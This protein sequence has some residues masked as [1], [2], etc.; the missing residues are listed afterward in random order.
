MPQT[1][2]KATCHSNAQTEQQSLP[3]SSPA[4][5][6]VE[7]VPQTTKLPSSEKPIQVRMKAPR[8]NT[9]NQYDHDKNIYADWF[10]IA[11]GLNI[12][13]DVVY[14]TM[15]NHLCLQTKLLTSTF[16]VPERVLHHFVNFWTEEMSAKPHPLK[17]DR[18]PYRAPEN[19][20]GQFL[21]YKKFQ[22]RH[23]NCIESGC[24]F[25][26]KWGIPVH[27]TNT[28]NLYVKGQHGLKFQPVMD[29]CKVPH[30]IQKQ[31]LSDFEK[32]HK[33]LAIAHDLTKDLLHTNFANVIPTLKQ[34]RNAKYYQRC[35]KR[36]DHDQFVALKRNVLL[37]PDQFTMFTPK[38]DFEAA[39][40]NNFNFAYASNRLL[41]IG[42]EAACL[43]CGFDGV[44]KLAQDKYPVYVLTTV[45]N[46]L[47]CVPLAIFVMKTN[48]SENLCC[49]LT[50]FRELMKARFKMNW[51]PFVMID[52]G[53]AEHA[54]CKKADLIYILCWFHMKKTVT[55]RL[56]SYKLD[57]MVT[58][59]I[60][61][62]INMMAL[63]KSESTYHTVFNEFK[64][65]YKQT[66]FFSYYLQEWHCQFQ[67]WTMIYRLS[68]YSLW[69]TNNY[70]ERC[71]W[72][73]E[74]V[75]GKHSI[76]RM[77]DFVS[78]FASFFGRKM[79]LLK[80]A[81]KKSATYKAMEARLE[82]AKKLNLEA[83]KIWHN[84]A[85][86]QYSLP[87]ASIPN[88]KYFICLVQESC[89]CEDYV[90]SHH[91]CKH[92]YC[93]MLLYLKHHSIGDTELYSN[94]VSLKRTI[95]RHIQDKSQVF[96]VDSSKGMNKA[97]KSANSNTQLS[98]TERRLIS[99]DLQAEYLQQKLQDT[100]ASASTTTS[101]NEWIVERVDYVYFKGP[102]GYMRCFWKGD[103]PVSDTHIQYNVEAFVQFIKNIENHMRPFL[104]YLL[105]VQIAH[106]VTG[107]IFTTSVQ[108]ELSNGEKQLLN[109]LNVAKVYAFL[110]KLRKHM[111]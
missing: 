13:S 87:S 66:G 36:T 73:I 64:D 104:A 75:G 44:F 4:I 16:R 1:P 45:L 2:T 80:E 23:P 26:F 10:P 15:Y 8:L 17:L 85:Y 82:T 65:K 5:T 7:I 19:F 100:Q 20:S 70:T 59:D 28:I 55:T 39:T 72:E 71:I 57:P 53:A 108:L 61:R 110:T 11:T 90:S 77:D 102:T 107:I 41:E 49:C 101:C 51:N 96:I 88:V 12:S 34:L 89:E 74:Q 93:C 24:T 40:C 21:C 95:Q 31:I 91:D 58:L 94:P 67:H 68:S 47:Q 14:K 30:H 22:C 83:S 42:K 29:Y 35:K 33:P 106:D 111:Q 32:R 37:N 38:Q 18:N 103:Y 54:A 62:Y 9:S 25:Q 43:I 69:N 78:T 105:D 109:T 6:F 79:L 46:D 50:W 98:G 99:R 81:P 48:S 52:D 92:L 27:P 86:T 56:R 76:Y 97:P 3:S 63:T 84:D 60:F